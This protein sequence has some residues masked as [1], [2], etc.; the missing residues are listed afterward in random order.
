MKH[1]IICRIRPDFKRQ[2]ESQHGISK[3]NTQKM[4]LVRLLSKPLKYIFLEC[5][6]CSLKDI[7]NVQRHYEI[8]YTLIT[9]GFINPLF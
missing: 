7:L 4:C 6:A 9:L 8:K 1:D 2:A 5:A 3:K